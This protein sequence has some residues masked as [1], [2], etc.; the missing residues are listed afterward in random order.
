MR[1]IHIFAI[2]FVLCM[3]TQ[4]V[5]AAVVT[6]VGGDLQLLA[7]SPTQVNSLKS[8]TTIYA[9]VERESFSLGVPLTMDVADNVTTW[10]NSSSYPDPSPILAAGT[11]VDSTFITFRSDDFGGNR[12][13]SGQIVFERPVLGLI[14]SNEASQGRGFNYLQV[15]DGI[16]GLPTTDYQM[17]EA[18]IVRRFV[19]GENHDYVQLA[20]DGRT[21]NLYMGAG[22]G[23][24]DQLRVITEAAD[25][26]PAPLAVVAGP[27]LFICFRKRKRISQ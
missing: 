23:G 1:R 20:A 18:E 6:S 13:V 19:I 24:Y 10:T 16:L 5:R 26:I 25:P 15:S 17:P 3:T 8:A 2:G 4:A 27:L 12:F 21:L 9:F 11:E 14:M 7:T 22:P